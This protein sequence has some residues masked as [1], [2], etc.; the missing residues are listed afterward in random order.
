M[1]D[2]IGAIWIPN[3][4]FFPNRDGYKPSYIILH[5]TAGGTNAVA[6]A[7][8]FA[9][10]Q[11]TANPVSAHYVVG[12]DG[13]VVQCNNES[14]GAYSNGYV[15]G[16]SGTSGNGNGNGYHDSWW[17]SDINPNL[18]T[19]SIE[20]VKSATDNSNQLTAAQQQASF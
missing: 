12:T 1:P 4:N 19:I 13:V 6:I 16:A 17:D 5:G 7:D 9:S 14:D 3:K 10:T 18:L 8:Y 15:S 2:E 11:N 20:H